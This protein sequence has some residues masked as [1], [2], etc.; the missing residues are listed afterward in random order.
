MQ[1]IFNELHCSYLLGDLNRSEFEGE[2]FS[3]LFNNQEKTCL[4]HWQN[5]EYEDFL[6]WFYPRLR[7]SIDSYR[8]KGASFD[9][10]LKKYFLLSS[11]EYRTRKISGA[12]TEYSAWS[13]RIRDMYAHEEAPS[14]TVNRTEDLISQ[15][16]FDKGGR[17]N[18]R[19]VLALILKCYYYVSDSFA[20]KIAK[21][22]G[23]NSDELTELLSKIRKL[24]QEKDDSIYYL[25]ERI[26][27][28]YYRCIVYDKRLSLMKE[29]PIAHSNQKIKLEKARTRLE[30]M[31]ARLSNIRTEA[32]NKQI[33]EVIG[34]TKG[35]VDASL[36]RL[37]AKWKEM[38][39]KANLN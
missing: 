15:I 12:V 4:I 26:Y 9:A 14:Y 16:I 29:N 38:A 31:R 18:T 28:Q 3:Y 36:S 32:T 6:S 5:E 39:K 17:K 23:V 24:R 34:I 2:I 11:K 22:I 7:R 1:Q 35:T 19:R 33:A 30:K 21:K 20:E 13:A 27:C 37:K 10:F 25:K 8:E